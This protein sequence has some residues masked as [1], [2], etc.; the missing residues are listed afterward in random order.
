[1]NDGVTPMAEARVA[2]PPAASTARLI[3]LMGA[4]A[5]ALLNHSQ[6]LLD[7]PAQHDHRAMAITAEQLAQKFNTAFPR[8]GKVKTSEIRE[9]CGN[10]S[11]AAITEWRR[12]GR[13]A[14]K[15]LPA[16]AKLSG[17]PLAWWLGEPDSADVGDRDIALTP[18][19]E[20]FLHLW[21][22]LMPAQQKELVR[23]MLD[24][25]ISNETIHRYMQGSPLNG[26]DNSAVAAAFGLPPEDYETS[27]ARGRA[28]KSKVSEPERR[29]P[30]RAQDDNE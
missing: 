1:M 30:D 16:L 10:V 7:I 18:R 22:Q 28:K 4:K 20:K 11:K 8:S 17:K 27:K 29:R 25:V 12:T 14:K 23:E 13:I 6:A 9:A 2:A 26:V 24:Q 19:E 21:R 15:H 3:A 5:K